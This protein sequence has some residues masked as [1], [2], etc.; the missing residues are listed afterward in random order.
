MS[1][2]DQGLGGNIA[3]TDEA[4]NT[5][6]DLLNN[7]TNSAPINQNSNNTNATSVDE[8]SLVDENGVGV[9]NDD[10][11]D[12]G[13][14][15]DG[16]GGGVENDDARAPPPGG[17]VKG[18]PVMA[19]TVED[20][21][22]E[23]DLP[24]PVPVP[25]C[26]SKLLAVRA[27]RI[28]NVTAC[29]CMN[30][31]FEQDIENA[32]GQAQISEFRRILQ[33]GEGDDNLRGGNG[34]NNNNQNGG[35]SKP[36][37]PINIV[38]KINVTEEVE[39]M[40]EISADEDEDDRTDQEVY[41]DLV[42]F[43]DDA[44]ENVCEYIKESANCCCEA[45]IETYAK[46]AYQNIFPD[47][48]NMTATCG[49]QCNLNENVDALMVD[50]DEKG[51]ELGIIFGAIAGV[52]GVAL[53]SYACYYWLF[54]LPAK[55]KRK[56]LKKPVTTKETFV[57]ENSGLEY[58]ISSMQGWRVYMEDRYIAY[59]SSVAPPTEIGVVDG[60]KRTAVGLPHNHSLFCVMDGHGGTF[61]SN[62][63][64]QNLVRIICEQQP[65]AEYVQKV[66]QEG[67]K[68]ER[69][70][71]E[72][73]ELL[74]ISLQHAFIDIDLDLLRSYTESK[75]KKHNNG[76]SI[77]TSKKGAFLSKSKKEEEH[78]DDAGFLSSNAKKAGGSGVFSGT[79]TVLVMLTPHFMV[80]A[81]VGDSRAVLYSSNVNSPMLVGPEPTALSIDHK[82]KVPSERERIEKF[83]GRV[84]RGR[85]DG[86]LAVS[87]A[88]GDFDFKNYSPHNKEETGL[89]IAHRQKVSPIPEIIVQNGCIGKDRFLVLACDG[90][91]DVLDNFQCAHL[92]ETLFQE[93]ESDVGLVCE[94]VLDVCLEKGSKDN[95]TIIVVK[96]PGQSIGKGG[97]VTARR[98]LRM[99]RVD[100]ESSSV[101][102][103]SAPDNENIEHAGKSKC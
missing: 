64:S 19:E 29:N 82:P 35:N 13:G 66:T 46:C 4:S 47:K 38:S 52:I 40:E 36:A 50:N 18:G 79:T 56:M 73:R 55:R 51:V 6:D 102:S 76:L 14:A 43:C 67:Q 75:E 49:Y 97:G 83:G 57:G 93:G 92:I 59:Q 17:A 20:S 33:E 1:D 87:R 27:C 16:N 61:S 25:E 28:D 42:E 98:E 71:F 3:I 34:Q 53:W 95:M 9:G 45:E 41:E 80:C 101:T 48:Y 8:A 68:S 15:G 103:F 65:F 74:E 31:S 89:E 100:D 5:I 84:A 77:S 12:D 58:G 44:N 24:P 72:L 39:V 85:V 94:E 26:E 7:N 86:E 78:D 81:N 90:I 88:L 10:R 60:E 11:N 91:W 70:L 32:F 63:V 23:V 30:S 69:D 2:D 21:E 37:G 22:E 99:T 62:F 96:F 54:Y